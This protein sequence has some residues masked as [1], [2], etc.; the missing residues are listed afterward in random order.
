MTE[1][2]NFSASLQSYRTTILYTVHICF[3]AH[4]V[5][6]LTNKNLSHLNSSLGS[7]IGDFFQMFFTCETQKQIHMHVDTYPKP[8]FHLR[9]GKEEI[10]WNAFHQ[11]MKKLIITLAKILKTWNI[12][13][14][15]L[16]WTEKSIPKQISPISFINVSK[17]QYMRTTLDFLLWMMIHLLFKLN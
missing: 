16:T 10:Y 12:V 3:V 4:A 13:G 5:H 2:K 14:R 11:A 7:F 17:R 8:K 15:C 9:V 1:D 6:W